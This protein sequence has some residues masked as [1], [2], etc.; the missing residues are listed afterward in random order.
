M[1]NQLETADHTKKR[2]NF[3]RSIQKTYLAPLK[4]IVFVQG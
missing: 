3:G 1:E 4:F 2:R